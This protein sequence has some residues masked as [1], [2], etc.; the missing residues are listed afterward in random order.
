MLAP[1]KD[2]LRTDQPLRGVSLWYV[3]RR[4][5]VSDRSDAWVLNYVRQLHDKEG[6]PAP[7]PY[8]DSRKKR[9]GIHLQS[10]WPRPAIDAWFEGFIPVHLVDVA[11]ERAAERDSQ[12]LDQRANELPRRAAGG[13]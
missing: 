10:R 1:T 2:D 9:D 7:L 12:L 6:F 13:R 5:G 8:Y 3:A 11:D 4:A